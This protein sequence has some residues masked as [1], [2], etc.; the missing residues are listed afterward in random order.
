MA[1]IG[2]VLT[3]LTSCQLTAVSGF[4]PNLEHKIV[5]Y[6]SSDEDFPNPERGFFVAV[7][8]IS[9]SPIS[10]LKLSDLQSVRS[11]NMTLVRRIYL[12]SEFRDKP[13]SKSF[14]DLVSQDCESARKAGVKLIIRFSYNWLGGGADAP[15]DRI[16][17]HLDQLQAILATNYDAIAYMEAGFI[18]YWGEWNRSVNGLD[19]N[20]E[21]WKKI[22]FKILSVLPS[23]RM[24][25]IR[26]SRHKQEAFNN[27]LPL[28]PPEAFSGT[29]RSRIGFHNDCFLSSIDDKGTY[30]ST[31]PMIVDAQKD[32]LSKENRYVVQGGETCQSSEYD[33]CPNALKELSRMRWSSLNIDN[34]DTREIINK[35]NIQGCLLQIKRKLGYR[36]RL[37]K[38]LSPHQ[39]K[40]GNTLVVKVEIVNDGWA[41]PYNHRG[42]EIILRNRKNRKEYY[43]PVKEDPRRWMPGTTKMVN[44]EGGIPKAMPPGVYEVLLNLPDPAPR[45]YNRMQY[46]I[47]FANKNVWEATTGYNS[48]LQTVIIAPS[49]ERD[50]YSGEDFFRLR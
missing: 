20:S 11:Q 29:Y 50:N 40:A 28:Q 1:V 13:L 2:L 43:L 21:D 31:N 37:S 12:L 17:L 9:K 19:K 32:F 7:N 18:G 3:S 8:P 27:I 47:R 25:A 38:T 41:S 46:S 34:V 10:P 42:L 33:N 36:F 5:R 49:G 44:I 22:L 45:L 14:L 23:H 35:W 4:E 15:R 48:L 24:V 39:V 6:Q 26:Y 16:L 30:K